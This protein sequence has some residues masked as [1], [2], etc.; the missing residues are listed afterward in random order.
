MTAIKA[1]LELKKLPLPAPIVPSD[2]LYRVAWNASIDACVAAMEG[3]QVDLDT[4][5]LEL[6]SAIAAR[7]I[8]ISGDD[9]IKLSEFIVFN[10][11]LFRAARLVQ[12]RGI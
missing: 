8:Q 12:P 2:Q 3:M 4:L 10:F 5:D 9:R 1:L 11:V 7:D 6:S